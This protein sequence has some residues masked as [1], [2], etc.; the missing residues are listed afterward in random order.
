MPGLT[1]RSH[2]SGRTS[3]SYAGASGSFAATGMPVDRPAVRRL[4][5]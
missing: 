5:C 4:R 2:G 1:P 3:V